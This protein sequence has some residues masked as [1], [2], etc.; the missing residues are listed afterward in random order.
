M[1]ILNNT[2]NGKRTVGKANRVIN[3][4]KKCINLKRERER[5]KKKK[6][7][8]NPTELQKAKLEAEVPKRNKKCDIKKFQMLK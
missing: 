3:T 2:Y 6:K 4:G 8:E 7:Q 1:H 5:K